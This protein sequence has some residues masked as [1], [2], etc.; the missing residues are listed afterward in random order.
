MIDA[1]SEDIEK[2]LYV[3]DLAVYC[4]YST[5]GLTERRLQDFL[6][7]LITFADENGFKLFPTKTLSMHFGNKNGLQ[8]VPSL[9]RFGQQLHVVHIHWCFL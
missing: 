7:K 4:Q 5:M 8:P 1:L 3:N 6:D 2:S 9:K